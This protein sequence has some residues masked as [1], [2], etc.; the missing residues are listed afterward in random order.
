LHAL[1]VLLYSSTFF[2]HSI[3]ML[4]FEVN[5]NNW[6]LQAS[7]QKLIKGLQSL[8][9]SILDVNGHRWHDDYNKFKAG[10]KD[11]EVMLTNV[12]QLSFDNASSLV[13]RIELLEACACAK[14][15]SLCHDT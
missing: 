6:C 12:I 10:I 2:D 9:Y 1:A 5:N 11:L 15:C 7:F 13:A 8:D 3:I 4:L 14:Q